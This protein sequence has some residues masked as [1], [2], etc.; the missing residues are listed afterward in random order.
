LMA[1]FSLS[2]SCSVIGIHYTKN[3]TRRGRGSKSSRVYFINY[4]K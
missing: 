2:R 4:K 1:E 3:L